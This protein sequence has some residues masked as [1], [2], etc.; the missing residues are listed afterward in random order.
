MVRKV[1][2]TELRLWGS[3]PLISPVGLAYSA[4][5]PYRHIAVAD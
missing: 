2:L 3:P 1:D 5:G 4:S